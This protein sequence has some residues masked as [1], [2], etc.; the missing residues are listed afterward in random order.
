MEK[1]INPYVEH[2]QKNL[3]IKKM[4]VSVPIE[5]YETIQKERQRRIDNKMRHATASE[6]LC[7]AFAHAFTGQPLPT[8]E[9]L[10]RYVSKAK[11]EK[12][13]LLRKRNKE[14]AVRNASVVAETYIN[15]TEFREHLMAI[16]SNQQFKDSERMVHTYRLVNLLIIY[17]ISDVMSPYLLRKESQ[18][19]VGS[20]E[21]ISKY[22]HFLDFLDYNIESNNLH[23]NIAREV[24]KILSINERPKMQSY[25]RD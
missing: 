21:K 20:L 15:T 14:E 25:R 2:G 4:T 23:A 22:P 6:L 17:I 11:A 9:E 16:I 18:N 5:I 8:D 12:Y 19:S 7:E 13:D 10:F 24:K 1:H 3:R